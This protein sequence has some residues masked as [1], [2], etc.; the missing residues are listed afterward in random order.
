MASGNFTQNESFR[1]VIRQAA[2]VNLWFFTKFVTGFSGPF[3]LLN[4][5]LHIDMA[6]FRQ[7]LLYPGCRGAMYLPRGHYKSA[8]LTE[9]GS[10]WEMIRNPEI[11]IRIT[12]A[13]EDKARDFFIN[14]KGI[15]DSND[16]MSW[17]FGN[18][19][20]PMGSFVPERKA[21]DRWNR[22]ELVLPNRMRN[23][24]EAN[25]EYGG[26]G[27]ASEGHHYDLHVIDDM[28]GLAALNSLQGSNA[29]M[30]TTR[31]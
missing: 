15:F 4:Y 28:I 2:L 1:Q 8:I 18:P 25:L 9:G 29:V 16:L 11:R 17:L 10:A 13:T 19:A 21:G 12:N 24:R 23:Y 26:V 31:N 6:N 30:E 27:G 5:D 22:T 7:T 20:D 14:V 3:D